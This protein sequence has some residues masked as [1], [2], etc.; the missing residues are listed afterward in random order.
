MICH[1]VLAALE[2]A[3]ATTIV[4][5]VEASTTITVVTCLTSRTRASDLS[6]TIVA[7]SRDEVAIMGHTKA[8]HLWLQELP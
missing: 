8:R 2:E 7:A 4:V 1:P 5:D 3:G 6:R